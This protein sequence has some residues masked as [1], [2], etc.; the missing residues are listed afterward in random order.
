MSYERSGFPR[1]VGEDL[2]RHVFGKSGIAS[3][4]SQG[5]RVNHSQMAMNEFC[6]GGFASVS[7]EQAK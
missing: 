7:Y 5:R 6:K 1:Q 4:F 3:E 2:L